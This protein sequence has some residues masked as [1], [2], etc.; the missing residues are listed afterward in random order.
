M[1]LNI[2]QQCY[3]ELFLNFPF[4]SNSMSLQSIYPVSYYFHTD[5]GIYGFLPKQKDKY[6]LFTLSD[7]HRKVFSLFIFF[8]GALVTRPTELH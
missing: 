4:N 1:A 3:Q 8:S 6:I 2:P 5:T 7:A